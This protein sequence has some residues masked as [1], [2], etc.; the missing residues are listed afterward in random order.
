[1]G[2]D[3]DND[4]KREGRERRSGERKNRPPIYIFEKRGPSATH[5]IN[6]ALT[7]SFILILDRS[8][9]SSYPY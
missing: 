9:L 1:L 2:D 6:Y 7:H 4:R 3:D 5:S 8:I